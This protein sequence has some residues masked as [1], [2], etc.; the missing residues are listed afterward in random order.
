ML[1]NSTGYLKPT[2]DV[3]NLRIRELEEVLII[4]TRVR[5]IYLRSFQ[6]RTCEKILDWKYRAKVALF[7]AKNK[8]MKSYMLYVILLHHCG[9]YWPLTLSYS[10]F[11][12]PDWTYLSLH[13]VAIVGSFRSE[14]D[15]KE[16]SSYYRLIII[17]DRQRYVR[18]ELR[19][20]RREV[21]WKRIIRN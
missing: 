20:S 15:R 7:W 5:I 11:Y 12:L 1:V 18:F 17:A 8:L 3:G 14:I 2:R 6:S 10:F 16:K 13:L 19:S 9:Q 4:R 21:N